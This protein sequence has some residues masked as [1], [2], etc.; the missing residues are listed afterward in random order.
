MNDENDEI[1]HRNKGK[2]GRWNTIPSIP[3]KSDEPNGC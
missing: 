3:E 1:M 2:M